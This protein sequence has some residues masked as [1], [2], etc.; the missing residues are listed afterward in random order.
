MQE[1]II[2]INAGSSSIKFAIFAAD[3]S[4]YPAVLYRGQISGIGNGEAQFTVQGD[5]HS[6]PIHDH[7]G[8]L[9]VL[10][11]WLDAHDDDLRVL[12]IGHR[13]VHGGSHHIR[14][15]LIDEAVMA[16]LEALIPL[17]PLHQPH[18]LSAIRALQQLHPDL[19]QAA[20]FDTAFHHTIPEVAHTFALPKFFYKEGVRRYGFH[21]L[22]YEY[23]MNVL[24]QH[25]AAEAD[26]RV[27][28]AHLGQGASLCAVRNRQSVATTMTFTPLDGLPMGTRCGSI[29]PAVVL[30][31]FREKNMTADAISDLLHHQSG[32]AGLSGISGDMKTLLSSEHADARKAVDIFVYHICREL[33][34]LAAALGGLDTLIFTAGIGERAAVIR[35]KVCKG[36]A[37]LGID[38]DP[39]ANRNNAAQ[40]S[41]AKSAV[42]VRVIPTNEE[43]MIAYHT[44]T[45]TIGGH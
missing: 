18:N 5:S 33:G 17:A 3:G 39:E 16:D 34:S 1:V 6:L 30:Y 36:A 14:P 35:D 43:Q 41:S 2:V 15:A 13:I 25:S 20:C 38:I 44:Y 27:V 28:I 7:Q 10:L 23:I 9:R 12:A 42:S 22:S 45:L 8:A 24:P 32:L 26:G 37:W 40:I 11:D 21:G 29:D 4:R 19:I 31:L